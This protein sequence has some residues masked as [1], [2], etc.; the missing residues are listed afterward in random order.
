MKAIVV[1]EGQPTLVSDRPVPLI[2]DGDVL[3][4][5]ETVAL[6]PTDWKHLEYKLVEDGCL[7]G[8]D[9]AGRVVEV[10]KSVNKPLSRGDRVAGVAHGGNSFIGRHEDGAFAE[11]IVAKG[12]ILI[13]LPESLNFEEAATLPLGVATVM[14]GLYQKGLKMS[15]PVNPSKENPFVLIYGG[16]TATGALGIQFAKLSGYTVLTTC[17]PR[18][19]KYV[20][21]LGADEVFDYNDI[22]AGLKIREFTKN[23]LLLVWD[24]ISTAASAQICANALS[25]VSTGCRYSSFLSNR[26]PREDVES[27][28]TNMYTVWGEYFRVG[29]LEYPANSADFEW[30]TKFMGLTEELLAKGQLKPHNYVMKQNGLAGVLTGLDD[31]KSNRI[32]AQKLVYRVSETP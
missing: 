19:S 32:S 20:Q 1:R 6:N 26:S 2:R 31:L 13:K 8:C 29:T 25:S 4:E 27:I 9:F 12:D 3:V 5:V 21:E 10:G 18:N 15:L 22:N 7:V 28:G 14:Q 24:I 23:N 30:A 11:Y 16:A 17:S